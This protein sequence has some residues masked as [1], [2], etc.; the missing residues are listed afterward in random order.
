MDKTSARK[1]GRS[2]SVLFS[3]LRFSSNVPSMQPEWLFVGKEAPDPEKLNDETPEL[4]ANGSDD[5][6]PAPHRTVWPVGARPDTAADAG[7]L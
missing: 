3:V 2:T 5:A 4:R 1:R 6:R 7:T